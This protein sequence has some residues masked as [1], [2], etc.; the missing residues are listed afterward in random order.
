MTL[1]S[2]LRRHTTVIAAVSA[3]AAS[4]LGAQSCL[5]YPAFPTGPINV[6]ASG[7]VGSDYG[8][9]SADFNVG[10]RKGGPFG[11]IGLGAIHYVTDPKET[12][13]SIGATAG[14]E[15]Y[16][17][18]QLIICPIVS[19]STERGTEVDRGADGI[20][21]TTGTVLGAGLGVGFELQARKRGL[22]YNP[23]LAARYTRV[24]TKISGGVADSTV[25]ETGAVVSF[26]LGV[27][28]K[29]AIQV[30]PSFSA[31]TFANS[32]LVFDLRVSL[33]LEFKKPAK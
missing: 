23:Y 19:A 20:Q 30:T 29:E 14:W 10:K 16:N 28:F 3:L 24:Q 5:G 27:R 4:P 25:T 17:K 11:S 33:A 21:R 8:G 6:S 22:S 9:A 7:I 1:H 12:R 31:A 32:N 15:R 13:T 2:A 18:D 26:G